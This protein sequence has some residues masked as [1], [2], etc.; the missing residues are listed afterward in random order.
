MR[1]YWVYGIST[2]LLGLL[3]LSIFIFG[4]LGGL[5]IT[6][7]LIKRH[8]VRRGHHNEITSYYFSAISLLY[9]L[10]LGQVTAITYQN[11]E[12]AKRAVSQESSAII[13]LFNELDSYPHPLKENVEDALVGYVKDIISKEWY[14][15]REGIFSLVSSI[16]LEEMEDSILNYE[17]ETENQKILHTQVIE[18]LNEVIETRSQRNQLVGTGLPATFWL[19]IVAGGVVTIFTS[20]LFYFENIRLHILLVVAFA[21]IIGLVVFLSVAMDHPFRG[22]VSVNVDPYKGALEFSAELKSRRDSLKAEKNKA[23]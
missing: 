17:P 15:H 2:P 8:F 18:T 11:F 3:I 14:E 5:L 19:V 22:D 7:P 16:K 23:D 13:S 1:L 20:F 10:I 9:A 6:R 21:T 12:G 4:S